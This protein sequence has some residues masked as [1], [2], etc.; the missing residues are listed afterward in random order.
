MACPFSRFGSAN[1]DDDEHKDE[2]EARIKKP[3]HRKDDRP[4]PPRQSSVQIASS[5]LGEEIDEPEDTQT[6]NLKHLKAAV[7][8]LTNPTVSL[9]NFYAG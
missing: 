7:L 9:R 5:L 1:T 3:H 4:K 6:L 2:A 8:M